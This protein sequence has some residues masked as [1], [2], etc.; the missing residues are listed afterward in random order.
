MS[1]DDYMKAYKLGKKDYQRH[2]ANGSYPYLQALEESIAPHIDIVSEVKLGLSQIPTELIA[3][4][5]TA[6]RRTAFAPNFMPLLDPRS[7]FAGKWISLCDSHLEEGIREPVTAC[8]FMGRYY[9]VEGNKRVSVLKYFDSPCIPAIVT[10]MVPR[11][12]EEPENIIYYEYMEFYRLTNVNYILFSKIGSFPKLAAAV[13][14]DSKKIWDESTREHFSSDFVKFKNAYLNKGG[15]MLSISFGDALLTYIGVYGYESLRTVSSTELKDN[16]TRIW[17]EFKLLEEN[18]SVELLMDP[19]QTTAKKTLFN[20][21]LPT[22]P[23]QAKIAFI[24][25][26]DASSSAWTYAHELGRRHVE[27]VFSEQVETLCMDHVAP[28]EEC[29][30]AIED[31]IAK[32]CSIIF[33][34]TPEFIPSSLKAAVN[35]PHIKILNCSLNTSHHYIRTYYGRMYEAKFLCGMIAGSLADNNRIGYIA[36]YPIYGMTANINAFALG[37]HLVN[38]RADIFLKW[39]TVKNDDVIEYFKKHNISYISS[40]DMIIPQYASRQYGLYRLDEHDNGTSPF[41]AA[42]PLWNWGKF[43]EKIIR[44]IMSGSWDGDDSADGT[45]ALNYWWGLSSGVVDMIYSQN[46][47]PGTKRLVAFMRRGIESGSFHPF[48]GI[49]YSQD[50]IVQTDENHTLAPEEII[51]MDWLAAN[52]IGSIPEFDTLTDAAKH[53]VLLSGIK[54]PAL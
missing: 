1:F 49:L 16:L 41:N 11:R 53:V 23:K 47:S 4:T 12:S 3:G 21:L 52:V 10:R 25:S 34:T 27:E 36:D 18:Q 31:A 13:S 42:T 19:A 14:G 29:Y 37:A 48:S 17:E 35:Y 24:H 46:L 40:Q 26:K 43:Y 9:I 5:K 45:R 15:E 51:T 6:G 50:G 2:L 7:E 20:L 38:P 28:G 33:T 39:S 54:K 8:E 44:S 30:H 22:S 32:G